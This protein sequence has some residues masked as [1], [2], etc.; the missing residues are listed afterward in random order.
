MKKILVTG[1]T[2]YIGS[3]TVVELYE[4]GYTPVIVDNLSNS[5]IGVLEQ[6][7]KI[8]GK[9]PD[10]HNFDLCDEQKVKEF[11]AGNPDIEGVIHFAAYKAVGE[12]VEKPLK[13]YYNN[14]FSLINLLNAFSSKRTNFV[15]SSSCTVY[16][17]P[18]ELP[19]T[20]AAEVKKA[21]SP[22]GNT[23]QIAEEIL[24]ETA[25]SNPNFHILSL[26]YFN[27]VGAHKSALIGEL[28]LGVPQNLV[29]FI[30]QTAIGKR[31]MITVYGDDYNT[32]DGS[33]IRDYI[34][35]VD[36]A[37]A[38]VAAI[39]LLEKDS[40]GKNYDVFNIGTG[41]GTS[42]LEVI[43]AF[44]KA[45]GEKLNYQIGSRRS[46]DVE[47][48]WGDVTKST[49]EL[50]WKAELDIEEMMR[51]AWAWEVYLKNENPFDTE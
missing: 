6:I 15:F 1:G 23:K 38:H 4:A 5:N 21:E 9:K 30:T 46:G 13:Y 29:P 12:S 19:V 3:H 2:G 20:E 25:A 48:V 31:E 51:S 22:Y 33:A 44:E 39:Q 26:R 8:T 16:G 35:V 32:P 43:H 27:P 17:Q 37:K 18:D 49:E 50:G 7:E 11:V 14:F 10:F 45:T 40:T 24:S 42:V 47:K 28:P 41:N 36:L 34:H